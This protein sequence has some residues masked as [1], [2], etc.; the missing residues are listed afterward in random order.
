MR[1]DQTSDYIKRRKY[2]PPDIAAKRY[3]SG[4]V[5]IISG[6]GNVIPL[7][8]P[9]TILSPAQPG[10]LEQSQFEKDRQA[11]LKEM[12]YDLDVLR[13]INVIGQSIIP[14][15]VSVI[16]KPVQLFKATDPKGLIILNPSASAGLTTTGTLL[17]S[18]A[19]AA[20][21]TGNTQSTP[22]GVSNFDHMSLFLNITVAGG[23]TV[24]I[25]TLTQNPL[26]LGWAIA[27]N[28]IFGVPSVTGEYYA[29]IGNLGIDTNFAIKYTIGAG[30]G[31]T[32]SLSYSLKDGLP[33]S[34]S[35]ILR[36]IYIGPNGVNT[37][38]GFD[39]LEGQTR[40]FFFNKNAEL[41]GISGIA[42]G[43]NIKLLEM[44]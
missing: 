16:N 24:R 13:Q 4:P 9:G 29:N 32:F 1:L 41:W 43:V 5:S 2:I 37:T 35:G 26:T 40:T 17:T 11:Y 30:G 23:G 44:S 39:L 15:V 28:D 38:A 33:G 27:N 14:R 8:Q 31:V 10:I 20:L 21:A 34:S 25:D 7:I 36:T 12:A 3:Q 22:I 6:G 19:Y 18:A 42:T